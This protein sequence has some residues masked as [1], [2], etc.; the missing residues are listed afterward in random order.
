VFTPDAEA[1][2]DV[3]KGQIREETEQAD[4]LEEYEDADKMA[5]ALEEEPVLAAQLMDEL[6]DSSDE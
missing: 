4:T 1:S 6:E 5:Q 3:I 2:Q